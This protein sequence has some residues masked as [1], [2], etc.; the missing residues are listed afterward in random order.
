MD[1]G[2][3]A[4]IAE[5]GRL[6]GADGIPARVAAE[7][8]DGAHLFAARRVIA[9]GRGVVGAA[10]VVVRGAIHARAPAAQE[11]R[12]VVGANI[13]IGLTRRKYVCAAAIAAAPTGQ[14]HSE[15]RSVDDI[16]AAIGRCEV[17]RAALVA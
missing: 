5:F 7:R 9:T 1:R 12:E 13:A 2:W 11:H 6:G 14:K 3:V 15:V 17:A 16:V 4:D 10:V 8:V